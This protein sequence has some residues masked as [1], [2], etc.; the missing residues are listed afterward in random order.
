MAPPTMTR[1]AL[2]VL[3][4]EQQNGVQNDESM[5]SDDGGV[6]EQ[7]SKSLPRARAGA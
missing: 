5:D 2:Y 6:N 4:S 1:T 7:R 3:L